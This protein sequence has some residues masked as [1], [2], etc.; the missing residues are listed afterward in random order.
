TVWTLG[1]VVGL[2]TVTDTVGALTPITFRAVATV[3]PASAVTKV[4]G[5]V[6]TA[7]VNA[8]VPIVP[9]VK[10]TDRFGNAIAAT[11]VSFVVGSGGGSVINSVVNT[12]ANG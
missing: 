9:Q 7:A 12:D 1:G 6:Q 10:V 3:G 5:D 2:Q 8:N 4:Q 11:P